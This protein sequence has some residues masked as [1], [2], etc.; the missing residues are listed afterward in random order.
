MRRCL[1]VANRT[2][3]GPE[4]QEELR[5]RIEAGPSSFYIL[6]PNTK[7]ADYALVDAATGV[8][9]PSLAFWA[10]NYRPPATDEEA[11]G[12][13]RQRLSQMLADLAALGVSADGDVGSSQPLEAIGKVFADNPVSYT[14]LTLPTKR[15]V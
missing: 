3:L 13:A 14:H 7:A 12:Q 4:L 6:V 2:L 5:R 10:T 8:L 11:A 1:V 9:P 15:I